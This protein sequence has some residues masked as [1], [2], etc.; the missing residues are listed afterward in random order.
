MIGP[1]TPVLYP[2]NRPWEDTAGPGE[3][4]NAVRHAERIGMDFVTCGDHGAVVAAD[5]PAYGTARLL[6]T[7]S[8]PSR[9]WR[10]SQRRSRRLSITCRAAGSSPQYASRTPG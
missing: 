5:R 2:I 1:S 7:R 6:R 9:D 10:P 8:P 4:L 3:I